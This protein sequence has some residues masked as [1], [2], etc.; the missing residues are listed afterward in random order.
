MNKIEPYIEARNLFIE[1]SKNIPLSMPIEFGSV[2]CPGISDIDIGLI[3]KDRPNNY[4][5][6]EYLGSFPEKVKTLMNGGTLMLFPEDILKN[7]EYIDDLNIKCLVGNIDIMHITD[8][9]KYLIGLIQIIEWLPERI[10]KIYKELKSANIN[11][12]RL[13]GFF[14][15]MCYSLKKIQEYTGFSKNINGF[16][17]RIY[18]LR[19]RWFNLEQDDID[20]ALQ[21]VSSNWLNI[22]LE[23]I[24][25]ISLVLSKYFLG[26]SGSRF[27]I[28]GD[29]NLI[30][31]KNISIINDQNSIFINIPSVFL[32]TYLAYSDYNS[33]LGSVINTRI[34]KSYYLISEEMATILDYRID[35]ISRLFDFVK[36]LGC[37]T[38]LYKFGWYI[39]E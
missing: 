18:E 22:V 36:A 9:E 30:A 24:D 16:I 39:N 12:K 4:N 29:V 3:L 33:V 13:V 20:M 37:Q 32:C 38:G 6:L 27:N 1:W 10:A 5:M 28:Y 14:Y 2:G 7:I 21:K 17:N 31:S 11:K 26:G 23:A 8:R 34:T 25:K 15:S 19:N 35:I